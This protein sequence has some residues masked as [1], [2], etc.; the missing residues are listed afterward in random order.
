MDRL[1]L[2]EQFEVHR[3]TEPEVSPDVAPQD[4][5]QAK[6]LAAVRT[7]D[8]VVGA[9]IRRVEV[10]AGLMTRLLQATAVESA[11]TTVRRRRRVMIA[12]L[13]SALTL[14]LA[15]GLSIWRWPEPTWNSDFVAQAA[16][17]F[18]S[19][20]Q[21]IPA[22][23]EATPPLPQIGVR[24]GLA[25]GYHEVK[26][27]SKHAAVY[28]LA[29]GHHEAVAILVHADWFPEGFSFVNSYVDSPNGL[30]EVRYRYVESTKQYCIL[31]G[32][33]LKPFE[34]KTIIL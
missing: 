5:M 20:R 8:N 13:S 6:R 14:S 26:F 21:G 11:V 32:P 31:I 3:P 12:G 22:P 33:D 24:D 25:I 1:D 30:L 17:K 18:Y 10:P 7:F 19:G 34:E 29:T 23:D 9:A 4:S 2:N 16:A 15:I 28:R 27:L